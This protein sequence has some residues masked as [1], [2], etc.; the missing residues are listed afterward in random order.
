MRDVLSGRSPAGSYCSR[1]TRDFVVP[2][3]GKRNLTD[4]PSDLTSLWLDQDD[5]IVFADP[6]I[7]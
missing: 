1:E 2:Q 3:A 6:R 7:L 4:E 5:Q